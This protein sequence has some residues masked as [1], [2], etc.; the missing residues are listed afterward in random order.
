MRVIAAA[1]VD[2]A[3]NAGSMAVARS[4]KRRTAS[5]VELPGD[6]GGFLWHLQRW[7]R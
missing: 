1:F 6:G 4:M 3:S 7:T 2:V 5:A